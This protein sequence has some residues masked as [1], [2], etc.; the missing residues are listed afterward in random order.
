MVMSL[1]AD[2]Q[3]NQVQTPEAPVD[4]LG[5]ADAPPVVDSDQAATEGTFSQT[6]GGEAPQASGPAQEQPAPE[7]PPQ[8]QPEQPQQPNRDQAA[9]IEELYRRRQVDAQRQWEQQV[10]R[11]A[12][13]MERRAQEQ[14]TDPQAA[15]QIGRQ[16]VMGQKELREQESKALDLVGFVEGRQNAA[17]HYALQNN[18]VSKQVI[19]DL[20]TLTRFRSPQEMELEAKRMSQL[21]SQ[22]AEIAQLKQGRVPPQTFDNSQGAAEATSNQDRLL[23]AYNNGDRSEAA[24]RAARRLALGS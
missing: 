19:E 9:A 11:K 10:I 8:Q 6:S 17:M 7:Q 4:D 24:V 21:R 16:Y 2:E 15:R 1:D 22:A 13:A 23:E 5:D 14:G 20:M 12:Q 3:Q 18:L